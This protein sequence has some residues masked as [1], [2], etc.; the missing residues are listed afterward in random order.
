MAR[1]LRM[2]FDQED[3]LPTF[4]ALS[5]RVAA[6]PFDAAAMHD[7]YLILQG[8]GRSEDARRALDTA[9]TLSRSFRI[10][11]GDGTG[12]CLLAFVAPGDFMA[13]TPLDFLLAGSNAVLWLHYVDAETRDLTDLPAHDVAFLAVAES[14]ANAPIH[15]RLQELLQ[16]WSGPILNNR[17]ETIAGLTRDGVAAMF[18]GEAA[19]V[20]PTNSRLDRAALTAVAGGKASLA[21]HVPGLTFPVVIRPVG[22]HAGGGMEK[23]DDRAA[24]A[25][26]LVAQAEATYFVAPFIDYAGPDGLYCKERVVL[27]DGQPFASHLAKSEHWMVHYLSAGMAENAGKRAIE[28]AWMAGFDEGY[29]RRHAEAFA[30]LQRRVGLDYFGMDCAELPDGRLLIFELD[31]AMVVHDMDSADLY[32]YKKPAMRKLFDAFLAAV[33]RRRVA[34]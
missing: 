30:A 29:A 24:L 18:E 1:V 20:V 7:M 9:L 17:P 3:I 4:E 14:E 12:P 16:D 21:D 27:I 26:Y 13:N 5:A 23:L 31:V 11:H 32:P 34:A 8:L 33:E 28:A 6:D 2:L 25:V 15:A 10:V 22:T 19:I